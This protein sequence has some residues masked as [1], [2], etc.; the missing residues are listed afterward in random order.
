MR[1][2]AGAGHGALRR[3]VVGQGRQVVDAERAR[4]AAGELGEAVP[5]VGEEVVHRDAVAGGR[6]D[7]R[8]V[9]AQVGD[10][11]AAARRGRGARRLDRSR[12]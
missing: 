11:L 5:A 8:A 4:G 6:V 10:L 9:D 12:V 3:E 1:F 7:E 2:V